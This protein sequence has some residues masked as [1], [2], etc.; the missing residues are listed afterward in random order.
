MATKGLTEDQVTPF[1]SPVPGQEPP[2]AKYKAEGGHILLKDRKDLRA[3]LMRRVPKTIHEDLEQLAYV[4]RRGKENVAV[5][6]MAI[7]IRELMRLN[8]IVRPT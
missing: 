6:C 2:P 5:E 7:G 1:I 8:G 3:Y 4:L